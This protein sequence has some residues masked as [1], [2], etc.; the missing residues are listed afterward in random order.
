MLV[1]RLPETRMRKWHCTDQQGLEHPDPE[2]QGLWGGE[3]SDGLDR[4]QGGAK[5]IRQNREG[6]M[7][8]NPLKEKDTV[9]AVWY[10]C[11]SWPPEEGG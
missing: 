1:K 7:H 8:V 6:A 4:G 3:R 9:K 5:V 2:S 10:W 11:P